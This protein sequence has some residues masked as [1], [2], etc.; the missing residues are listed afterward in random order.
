MKKRILSIAVAVILIAVV[1]TRADWAEV[2]RAIGRLEIAWLAAAAALFVPQTCVS[3]WRWNTLIASRRRQSLGQAVRQVLAASAANLFLPAKMGD[4]G[5]ALM[6]DGRLTVSWLAAR[7]LFEKLADVATLAGLGALGYIVSHGHGGAAVAVGLAVLGVHLFL[8]GRFDSDRPNRA[9][10]M[11]LSAQTLGLWCLHLAQIQLFLWAAGI[12]LSPLIAAPKVALSLF[13][14]VLPVSFCGIGTRD[15]ALAYFLHDDGAPAALA[16]VGMLTATR[17]IVPGL[18]G[19]PYL[20][21]HLPAILTRTMLIQ[22]PSKTGDEVPPA[23]FIMK[24]AKP[25]P[26]AIGPAPKRSSKRRR[27]AKSPTTTN[28]WAL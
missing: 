16:V 4:L 15:A 12:D 21:E 3:A 26:E 20:S 10:V 25:S 13:V 17:Y 11:L 14:G 6:V 2:F 19:T 23:R 5:K 8:A 1:C 18:V 22:L 7:A 27:S 9:A 24:T 28:R